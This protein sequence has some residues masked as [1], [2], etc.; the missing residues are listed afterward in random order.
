M[1]HYFLFPLIFFVFFIFIFAAFSTPSQSS[2][3]KSNQGQNSQDRKNYLSCR[4]V[5]EQY[6]QDTNKLSPGQTSEPMQLG[7]PHNQIIINNELKGK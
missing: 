7:T 2:G 1:L 4:N 6:L 5:H 3:G